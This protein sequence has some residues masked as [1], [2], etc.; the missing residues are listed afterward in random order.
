MR[1]WLR[2]ARRDT[3]Y[4]P[5]RVIDV[6][7]YGGSRPDLLRLCLRTLAEHL[8]FPSGR[9][10]LLFQDCDFMP[11][12]AVE[13]IEIVREHGG[14]E[15]ARVH[16][17]TGQPGVFSYGW[18]ITAALDDLIRAPLV[19]HLE[20]DHEFIRPVDLDLVWDL[21]E[22]NPR[23]NQLRLNRRKNPSE[24]N[25]GAVK[26]VERTLH[27]GLRDAVCSSSKNWYFQPSIW[28][29]GYVRQRWLGHRD[30]VHHAAQHD[31]GLPD[32]RLPAEHYIDV[33]GLATLGGIGAPAYLRHTGGPERSLHT[34]LGRV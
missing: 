10:R 12:L 8:I 25:D 4:L 11:S 9:L 14:F 34:V 7:I 32:V 18:S 33:L 19:F 1:Q 29:V 21:F 17:P 15:A 20:E 31:L 5:G 13:C 23:L 24:E 22:S 27:A 16:H 2:P 6:M 26:V 30:N 28:R 3:G